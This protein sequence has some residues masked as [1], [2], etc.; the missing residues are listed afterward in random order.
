MEF[1]KGDKVIYHVPKCDLDYFG[2]SEK[3]GVVEEVFE[4]SR[5]AIVNFG[6]GFIGHNCFIIDL[7]DSCWH[8]RFSQLSHAA[9]VVPDSDPAQTYHY[10]KHYNELGIQPIEVMQ[11][12]L[13][14]TEFLGFLKGNIIK[15]SYRCGKKDDPKSELAKFERYQEWY[16]QALKGL[17]INPRE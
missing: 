6:E 2:V 10:D 8:C 15:Y 11:A 4:G 16:Q 7:P 5:Y 17:R 14:P 3:E 9:N 13:T 12:L 1:K